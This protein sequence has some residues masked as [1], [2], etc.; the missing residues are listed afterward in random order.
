MKTFF[1]NLRIGTRMILL[2]VVSF[3]VFAI[4]TFLTIN[5]Q[6]KSNTKQQLENTY[7]YFIN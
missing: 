1:D 6:L 3:V 4:V 2:S 5:I 7:K